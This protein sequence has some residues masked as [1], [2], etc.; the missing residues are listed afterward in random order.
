MCVCSSGFFRGPALFKGLLIGWHI[1]LRY[2]GKVE[3]LTRT[4]NKDK[5]RTE[6]ISQR[7]R[8]T[9]MVIG[10]SFSGRLRL[11]SIVDR[12]EIHGVHVENFKNH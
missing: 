3:N 5:L 11:C 9:P 6:T 12:A 7:K 8:E 1:Y 4:L 10:K 2:F